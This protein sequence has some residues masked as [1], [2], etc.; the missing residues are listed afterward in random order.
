MRISLH[1]G[2][3]FQVMVTALA[4]G[5]ASRSSRGD[6]WI[7]EHDTIG[8]TVIVRTISGS[9][10]LGKYVLERVRRAGAGATEVRS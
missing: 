2:F 9:V 4:C 8:D 6:T 3:G 1:V 10:G 5:D 7:A